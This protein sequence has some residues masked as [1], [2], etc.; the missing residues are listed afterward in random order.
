VADYWR[1]RLCRRRQVT[2]RTMV[3]QSEAEA[4]AVLRAVELFGGTCWVYEPG[5][6]H[7]R[8]YI[9]ESSFVLPPV[10]RTEPTPAAGRAGDPAGER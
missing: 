7:P 3:V 4:K 9:A 10:D 1:I 8:W 2:Q 6:T 5:Q